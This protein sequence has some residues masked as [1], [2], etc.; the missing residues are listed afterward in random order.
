M[1]TKTPRKDKKSESLMDLRLPIQ[2]RPRLGDATKQQLERA[3]A[4]YGREA[5]KCERKVEQLRKA[6]Q[7]QQLLERLGPEKEGERG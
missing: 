4:A 5:V 2:G 6:K 7:L 3:A 1:S